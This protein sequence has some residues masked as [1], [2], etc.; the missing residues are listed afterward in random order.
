MNFVDYREALGIGFDEAKKFDYFKTIMMNIL[1]YPTSNVPPLFSLKEYYVFCLSIGIDCES[2]GIT[3]DYFGK[4]IQLLNGCND[5][6]EF[7]SYYVFFVAALIDIE[8]KRISKKSCIDVLTDTLNQSRIPFDI[9]KDNGDYFIF[10]KG[11]TE[12]D[13]GLISA[14]LEWMKEYPISRE[15]FI[16]ALRQYS[17]GEYVRDVADNFRK[18][19]EDFLQEFLNNSKNLEENRSEICRRLKDSGADSSITNML[20]PLLSYYKKLNDEKVKHN[21]RLD[22]K[23]LEFIMYQTGVFIRMI[24]TLEKEA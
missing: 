24:I 17:N 9:I 12:L 3:Y 18:A 8:E 13:S 21:N 7:L 6:K 11:A 10:S 16:R 4:V 14:P 15:T 5:L 19:L 1:D 2:D 20:E 23:L 22:P